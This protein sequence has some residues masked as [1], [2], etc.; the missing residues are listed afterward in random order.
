MEKF[1]VTRF[2]KTGDPIG[3]FETYE[4]ALA[5]IA[6]YEEEDKCNNCY[7]PDSYEI[8][9]VDEAGK[10]KGYYINGIYVMI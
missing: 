4:S 10:E 1:Y 6:D 9:V 7:D 3:K 2:Y 5:A 8:A